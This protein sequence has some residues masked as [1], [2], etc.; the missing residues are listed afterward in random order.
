[1]VPEPSDRANYRYE[2]AAVYR[3]AADTWNRVRGADPAALDWIATVELEELGDRPLVD[4]GCGPGWHTSAMPSRSIALDLAPEMVRLALDAA[5][6]AMG[7][8]A[9][10]ASLPFATHRL[11]GALGW[12]S[13]VHVDRTAVPLAL[14][15][16]HRSLRPGA[17]VALG[18]LGQPGGQ[19]GPDLIQFADDDF[20]GRWFSRW[21]PHL[22]L[23]VLHLCG[24]SV[25]SFST[26]E[27]PARSDREFLRTEALAE[28]TAAS[29]LAGGMRLLLVGANPSPTSAAT[30]IPFGH[31]GNRFWPAVTAAGLPGTTRDP[32]ELLRAGIGMTDFSK[33]VTARASELS[34]EEVRDGWSRIGRLAEWLQPTAIAVLGITLLRVACD[35]KLKLGWLPAEYWPHGV[36]V[37][38]LPNPSGLNAHTNVADMANRLRSAMESPPAP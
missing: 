36:P 38:A 2:N 32:L 17:R 26:A 35:R 12:R 18:V 21:P 23:D 15:D 14:R 4:L 30:G 24:F 16:L 11:G 33:R 25:R 9:D 31:P 20:P 8:V 28:R 27:A 6:R 37:Y 5:P 7:V 19:L 29:T 1:M 34:D 3:A 10:L 22:W 13:Y